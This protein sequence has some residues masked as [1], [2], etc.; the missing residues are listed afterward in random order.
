[1]PSGVIT[2]WRVLSF[3]IPQGFACYRRWRGGY[4]IYEH[5]NGWRKVTKEQHERTVL[6]RYCGYRTEGVKQPK[7]PTVKSP[8]NT[9]QEPRLFCTSCGHGRNIIDLHK[10]VGG[11]L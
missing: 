5:F 3:Q 2:M 8:L 6:D 10:H 1:M 4:W 11:P 7:V 9:K